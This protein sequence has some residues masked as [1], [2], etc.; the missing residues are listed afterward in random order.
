[1]RAARSPVAVALRRH[2]RR[3]R[4]ALADTLSVYLRRRVLIVMF[5]GFSSGLPL[6]L[7]GSTLLRVDARDRGRSRHHRPVRAGRH[8]LHGEVPVGAAG[9]CARRARAVAPARAPARLADPVATPADRGDRV[10]GADQSRRPIRGWSRSARCWSP[11]ARRP[12]TS[13]SMRSGSKACP[14]ASRRPA[15]R[16][17]SPPIAS[18]CSPRPRARC[19]WSAASRR[20][21]SP[22]TAPGAP[23]TSPWPSLV[24]IG[25]ITT[26]DRDRAGEIGAGARGSCAAQSVP[27][28]HRGGHRRV[29]RFPAVRL[30]RPDPRLRGAVQVHR[31]AGGG[32]DGAVR[33][34]SRIFAQRVSPRSSRASASPRPCSAASPAA[35]SPAPIR[36]RRAC[37]SAACCRRRRTSPFRGRRSSATT[38]PGSP[39]RSSPRISPA[40]SAR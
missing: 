37:G 16:P 9:R 12:R 31:R 29:P 19:S 26:L 2:P 35:S 33:H 20:W 27:A 39:S 4:P 15:W 13:S 24:V 22:R 5:L 30:C 21:A 38:S 7:S 28:R 40:P 3:P 17:M 6:A 23:A 8:A 34:R 25:M 1:M 11:P 36:W 32:D 10:S 18:A 14:K